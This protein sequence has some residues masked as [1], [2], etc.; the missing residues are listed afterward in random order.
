MASEKSWESEVIKF[1]MLFNPS[2]ITSAVAGL[3]IP[4]GTLGDQ[5]PLSLM[6]TSKGLRFNITEQDASICD[7][8]SRQWTGWVH[9]SDEKALFFC[10]IDLPSNRIVADYE[11][12]SSRVVLIR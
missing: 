10:T 5:T 4:F 9:V 1:K 3:A 2:R 8:G 7:A 6:S 12:G 11:K